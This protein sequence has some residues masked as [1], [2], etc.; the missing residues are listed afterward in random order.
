MTK[1][2]DIKWLQP[3]F[4][5]HA[6]WTYNSDFFFFF[7]FT[8]YIIRKGCVNF[9]LNL[10]SPQYLINRYI[11]V[12]SMENL[13]NLKKKKI[14]G[15]TAKLWHKNVNIAIQSSQLKSVSCMYLSMQYHNFERGFIKRKC[16]HVQILL[17][18]KVNVPITLYASEMESIQVID[19]GLIIW[20]N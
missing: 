7:F 16:I 19:S 2:T 14:Q 10:D 9:F 11:W 12:G 15:N 6:W 5:A 3:F 18:I 13:R 4:K 8:E 17:H 1:G 20:Y